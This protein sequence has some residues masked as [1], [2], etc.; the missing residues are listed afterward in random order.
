MS[1][2]LIPRGQMPQIREEDYL[3]L[4][5]FL[6]GQGV[7]F[8]AGW[9]TSRHFLCHQS[10]GEFDL[11]R[12]SFDLRR[13]PII[14]SEELAIVDGNHRWYGHQLTHSPVPYFRLVGLDFPKAV[15]LLNAYPKAYNVET[16]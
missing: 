6:G 11:S 15:G 2:V 1:D 13:K 9:R 14:V 4:F 7:G 3:D 16:D 5:L 10:V 12:F 8:D